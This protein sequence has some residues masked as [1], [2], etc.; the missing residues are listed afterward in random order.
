M[1]KWKEKQKHYVGF[2]VD[3]ED[4]QKIN[5]MSA[6]LFDNNRS[7]YLNSL[8]KADIEKNYKKTTNKLDKKE[9]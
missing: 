1:S 4:F 7:D 9:E 5:V 8:V 3:K 2:Y 6:L